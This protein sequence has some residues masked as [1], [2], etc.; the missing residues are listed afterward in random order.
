MNY[1]VLHIHAITASPQLEA[2]THVG[3][4]MANIYSTTHV[5]TETN[6]N[7]SLFLALFKNS[8]LPSTSLKNA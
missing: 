5:G 2:F 4:M 7:F 3:N 1:P 6:I 8:E